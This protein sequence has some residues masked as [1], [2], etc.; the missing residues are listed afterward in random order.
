MPVMN[1][2]ETVVEDLKSLSP[3]KLEAVADYIRSLREPGRFDDLAGCLSE[4]EADRLE[5]AIEESCER[6]ESGHEGW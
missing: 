3:D 5:K 2:L 1:A 6:V 4:E